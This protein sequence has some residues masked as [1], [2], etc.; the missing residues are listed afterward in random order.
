MRERRLLKRGE[1]VSAAEH[2]QAL[3]L[4][5]TL[6]T[7]LQP[8]P[9]SRAIARQH[10]ECLS[11]ASHSYP[12]VVRVAEEGTLKLQ[13]AHGADGLGQVLAELF[14]L[15]DN[16]RLDRLKICS[17]RRIFSGLQSIRGCAWLDFSFG[18]DML[19]L[20]IPCNPSR[21]VDQTPDKQ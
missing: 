4:R 18:L 14:A 11:R 5:S 15:A 21:V 9:A 17:S 7:F 13:P 1:R 12:R 8:A 6:R 16:C 2:R 3:E 19:L 20:R 10:T